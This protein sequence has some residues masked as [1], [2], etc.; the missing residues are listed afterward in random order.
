MQQTLILDARP[1]D[2]IRIENCHE[3][4]KEEVELDGWWRLWDRVH[5]SNPAK[6][7]KIQQSKKTIGGPKLDHH[8]WRKRGSG[9]G[10]KRSDQVKSCECVD[11]R[12]LIFP[13]VCSV[14]SFFAASKF[15]K[16]RN[17]DE[18][19]KKHIALQHFYTWFEDSQALDRILNMVKKR[20]LQDE[21]LVTE[22]VYLTKRV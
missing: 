18:N 16:R 9:A 20:K 13:F 8:L 21:A 22:I 14:K 7:W 3:I 15:K 6:C 17:K 10:W 4:L 1:E 12:K 11:Q 2:V 5:S 19:N